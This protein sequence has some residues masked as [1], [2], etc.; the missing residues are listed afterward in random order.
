MNA[1]VVGFYTPHFFLASEVRSI[2]GL[3]HLLLQTIRPF[4]ILNIFRTLD[5]IRPKKAEIEGNR[6]KIPQGV[7]ANK[8]LPIPDTYMRLPP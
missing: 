4:R 1:G 5:G 8:H 7:D 6:R 3:I 2:G